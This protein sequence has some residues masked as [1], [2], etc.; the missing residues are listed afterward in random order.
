MIWKTAHHRAKWTEI[1]DVG[2]QH[3]WCTFVPCSVQSHFGV[4]WCTKTC[5]SET[6]IFKM[7]FQMFWFF[8]NWISLVGISG[9]NEKKPMKILNILEVDTDRLKLTEIWDTRT[10]MG[11]FWFMVFKVILGSFR[12]LVIF[13]IILF[14]CYSLM[15]FFFYPNVFTYLW[16]KVILRL[17]NTRFWKWLVR[18]SW[19][20]NLQ[21][22][23]LK[24]VA[25]APLTLILGTLDL[26]V[27]K[28]IWDHSV[29]FSQNCCN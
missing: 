2:V 4:I 19:K 18:A 5:F 12:T 24:F 6:M 9:K 13:P 3:I 8:S 22:N 23:G 29:Q 11:Y 25:E 14:K 1:C 16:F 10:Y 7:L 27:F 17:C 15:S 26:V 21:Q 20:R 28:A